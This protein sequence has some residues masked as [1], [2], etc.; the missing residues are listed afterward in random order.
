MPC[1]LL[2][3]LISG[4]VSKEGRE[5]TW[6]YI[7]VIHVRGDLGPWVA[8]WAVGVSSEVVRSLEVSGHTES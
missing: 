6:S 7:S 1:W 5:I 4:A 2:G 8:G 3:L